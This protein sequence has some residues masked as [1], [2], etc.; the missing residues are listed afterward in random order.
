MANNPSSIGSF[1]IGSS[2]IGGPGGFAWSQ[3][4][5][6]Q[7]AASPTLTA[8][9]NSFNDAVEP[10][11][12]IS[13]I[14]SY[15]WD[16]QTAV[17]QGLNNWGQIVGVQRTLNV[18]LASP[19]Y[20]GFK[21][22]YQLATQRTGAQTFGSAPMFG[23][24]SVTTTY[25]LGDNDYRTLIMAK[26]AA[27]ICNLTA[28]TVNAI[29]SS[30]YGASGRVYSQDT[31]G[32]SQRYVFEFQ[33]SSVQ[34][35]IITQARVIPRS[36]GVAAYALILPANSFAFNEAGGSTFGSST[37]FPTSGLTNAA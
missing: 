16:I 32:M 25:S 18:A 31:G 23:G 7:Y 6:S 8:L 22:A 2:P 12:D 28:P 24:P 34:L 15:L 35:A 1:G 20:L 5:L 10:T 26:A 33:P 30:I 3:T 37:L 13:N 14:Y 36:A 29:L 27:N 11:G 17:G 9:I 21:E 4:I 19:N